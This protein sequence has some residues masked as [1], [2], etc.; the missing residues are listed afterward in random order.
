MAEPDNCNLLTMVKAVNSHSHEN[1]DQACFPFL[2]LP[3]ELRQCIYEHVLIHEKPIDRQDPIDLALLQT[4]RQIYRESWQVYYKC[5]LFM[6]GERSNDQ[7][8]LQCIGGERRQSIRRT[9][10][11]SARGGDLNYPV[12]NLL[13]Q[14]SNLSLSLKTS[15]S[16]LSG[17]LYHGHLDNLHGIPNVTFT[18]LRKD[19]MKH[20]TPTWPLSWDRHIDLPGN[21]M[22]HLKSRCLGTCQYHAD[23]AKPGINFAV[24]VEV[25]DCC[26][27][28]L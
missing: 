11:S 5:N 1:E 9:E 3:G 21:L 27:Y 6:L 19:C 12:F 22:D 15:I 2:Q 10:F 24:H 16:Q 14:C 23:K 13:S 20:R 8:W 28:S 17:F 18:E 25:G 7:K 4:C 26:Q